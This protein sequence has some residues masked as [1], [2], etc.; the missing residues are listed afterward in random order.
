MPLK[1]ACGI[2]E[3]LLHELQTMSAHLLE[4][5]PEVHLPPAAIHCCSAETGEGIEEL[6]ESIASL[7]NDGNANLLDNADWDTSL[8]DVGTSQESTVATVSNACW[9]ATVTAE[10]CSRT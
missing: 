5:H 7:L 1:C 6:V 3:E 4:L 9:S 10:H 2:Q 8:P